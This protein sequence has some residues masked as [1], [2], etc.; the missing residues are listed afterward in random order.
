MC[1]ENYQ[2][3]KVGKRKSYSEK[4]IE[5]GE[6]KRFLINIGTKFSLLFDFELL[7]FDSFLPRN[8]IDGFRY[9]DRMRFFLFSYLYEARL[10]SIA[11]HQE[12]VTKL[13][14]QEKNFNL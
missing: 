4:R 9:T 2:K 12:I 1:K 6:R 5:K 3:R 13:E 7:N 14:N 11:E 10:E 8:N